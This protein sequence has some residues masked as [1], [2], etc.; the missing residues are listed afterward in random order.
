MIRGKNRKKLLLCTLL[1]ATLTT[2]HVIP[3]FNFN[4]FLT[5]NVADLFPERLKVKHVL[6]TAGI[7]G[8]VIGTVKLINYFRWTDKK[9]VRWIKKNLET[10]AKES[11]EFLNAPDEAAIIAIATRI[12][13]SSP[14]W[15]NTMRAAAP[16]HYTEDILVNHLA[17]L[18]SIMTE[19]IKREFLTETF[20]DEALRFTRIILP[21]IKTIRCCAEYRAETV[22]IEKINNSRK[23]LSIQEQQLACQY[24]IARN[25]GRF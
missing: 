20:I 23:Q 18:R 5:Q 9:T 25:T 4:L 15:D 11:S 13:A 1:G 3:T 16:L 8:A 10:V 17:T 21:A 12:G 6:M 2:Q 14:A 22:E 19:C 24:E 7:I